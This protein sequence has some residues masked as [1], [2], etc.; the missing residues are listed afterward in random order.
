MF[1]LSF[2][3]IET[4]NHAQECTSYALDEDGS[5]VVSSECRDFNANHEIL[6][7]FKLRKISVVG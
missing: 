7:E 5:E 3:N 1:I 2:Q 6:G 4:I